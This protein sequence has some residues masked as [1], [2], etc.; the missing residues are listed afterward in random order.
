MLVK[1]IIVEQRMTDYITRAR[2]LEDFA[3]EANTNQLKLTANTLDP[4]SPSRFEY[5]PAYKNYGYFFST[6]SSNT[7]SYRTNFYYPPGPDSKPQF[8]VEK[9]VTLVLDGFKLQNLRGMKKTPRMTF[10]T[11]DVTYP[12]RL[13]VD[14]DDPAPQTLPKVE[15]SWK[16]VLNFF[17]TKVEPQ[18][19][20]EPRISISHARQDLEKWKKAFESGNTTQA[21]NIIRKI[22]RDYKLS[23]TELDAFH[24]RLMRYKEFWRGRQEAYIGEAEERFYYTKPV[25]K[26]L[27]KYIKEIHWHIPMILERNPTTG[28]PTGKQTIDPAYERQVIQILKWTQKYNIKGCVFFNPND[29]AI[30]NRRKCVPIDVFNSRLKKVATGSKR[31]RNVLSRVISA[32]QKGLEAGIS[33]RFRM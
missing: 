15:K 4:K 22:A 19:P 14:I 11:Y 32:F 13:T 26:N 9:D 30:V 5:N 1:E 3:A 24:M 2:S 33:R 27:H 16:S 31:P 23:D 8:D 28:L 12:D 25:I 10:N 18:K 21:V 20:D 7:N 6:S 29:Y 17:K